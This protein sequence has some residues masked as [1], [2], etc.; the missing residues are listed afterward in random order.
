MTR[1]SS[2][3]LKSW[4]DIIINIARIIVKQNV[5]ITCK[6]P[7]V[8]HKDR[9]RMRARTRESARQPVWHMKYS[10]FKYVL[11]LLV[12]VE[13]TDVVVL[14]WLVVVL[15]PLVVVD[16]TVVVVDVMV[17]VVLDKDVVVVLVAL[18]VVDD[19][20]VVV[21]VRV[22]VVLLILVVVLDSLVVVDDMV[23]VVL[24]RHSVCSSSCVSGA[25][26][27]LQS[28][29]PR[30][31]QDSTSVRRRAM[32]VPQPVVMVVHSSG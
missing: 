22:V 18:V 9:H 11:V 25:R 5:N 26:L 3:L 7:N 27:L 24:A 21:L 19:T 13:V 17:V 15:V 29:P 32:P 14:V 23:V 16:D 4:N 31:E 2:Y 6:T 8:G 20:E 28:H 12:V 30:A 10:K 1:S